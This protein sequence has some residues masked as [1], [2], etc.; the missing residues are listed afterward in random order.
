MTTAERSVPL[1]TACVLGR[2]EERNLPRL[3]ASLEGL[4]DEI[5]YLDTGSTDRSVEIARSSG[6]KILESEWTADFAFH[7]NQSMDAATGKWLLIID[8]DEEVVQ[9]D[10]ADFRRHLEEE[11]HQVLTG[12]SAEL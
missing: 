4:A 1:V 12:T 10:K 6:A 2:N 5:V 8:S 7:R 9:T 3:F 11:R